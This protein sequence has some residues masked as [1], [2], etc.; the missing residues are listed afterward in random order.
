MDTWTLVGTIAYTQAYAL[1]ESLLILAVLFVLAFILPGKVYR[2]RFVAQ[3]SVALILAAGGAI[4]AHYKGTELGIWNA[5]GFLVW[6]GILLAL[7]GLSSWL[8]SRFDK[9]RK[10]IEALADRMQVLA[11]IY[12]AVGIISVVIVIIRNV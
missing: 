5:R 7:I 8:I 4:L 2:D 11:T 10:G 12:I 6:S 1:I 9:M 3:S